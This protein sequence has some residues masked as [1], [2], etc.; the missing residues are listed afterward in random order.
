MLHETVAQYE[1]ILAKQ[2]RLSEK[3]R[4]IHQK[5]VISLQMLCALDSNDSPKIAELQPKLSPWMESKANEGFIEYLKARASLA[6]DDTADAEFRF[7]LVKDQYPKLALARLSDE[8]LKNLSGEDASDEDN[9]IPSENAEKSSFSEIL[10]VSSPIS[11]YLPPFGQ[12]RILS[13]LLMV[14]SLLSIWGG[15]IVVAIVSALTHNYT[16]EVLWVYFPFSLIP[17][18]SIVY[19]FSLKKKGFRYK[20]NVII[21]FIMAIILCTFASFPL[22][23]KDVY[24]HSEESILVVEQSIGIDL[25]PHTHI[26]T[27]DWTI[28]TQE[29]SRGYIFSTSNVYF[30]EKNVTTFE[31]EL[32]GNEHWFSTFPSSMI[33][34]TSD[35][36]EL[37]SYD[38]CLL[39]NI[40]TNE[41]NKLPAESG[42]YR[43]INLFYNSE[44]NEL[45]IVEY[46]I[47]YLK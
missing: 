39:Y 22:L 32:V 16:A 33:G 46:Q 26:D 29:I 6:L 20:K 41:L 23:F 21:G 30:D 36:S 17:I 4:L 2:K 45:L 9:D 14:G 25:P 35:F 1:Q 15:L 40:D 10:H 27:Q 3:S 5:V 11:S 12:Q 47:E 38:Y 19:G 31:A 28:G 44:D 34:I 42:T 24:S 8:A 43:M 7:R 18:L 13:I 37:A